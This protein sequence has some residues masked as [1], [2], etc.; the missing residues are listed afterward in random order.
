MHG[1]KSATH[2]AIAT[3]AAGI[4]EPDNGAGRQGMLRLKSTIVRGWTTPAWVT[5]METGSDEIAVLCG[6]AVERDAD[7]IAE[8]VVLNVFPA[9]LAGLSEVV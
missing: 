4:R 2:P 8:A 5:K 6:P 3:V 9:L 7:W 1:M